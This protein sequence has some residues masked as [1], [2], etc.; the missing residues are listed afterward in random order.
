MNTSTRQARAA[1][2]KA[3]LVRQEIRK[4]LGLPA[5]PLR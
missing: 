1:Y 4:H 2:R 3:L 5:K